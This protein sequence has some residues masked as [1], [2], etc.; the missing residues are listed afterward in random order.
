[1]HLCPTEAYC[2]DGAGSGPT[3]LYLN[4]PAFAGEQW[5]PVVHYANH[6]DSVR[7]SHRRANDWVLVGTIDDLSW[8]TCMTYDQIH[9]ERPEP[10]WGLDGS[11]PEL[12]E[13]ILC[14]QNPN[15]LLK[16]QTFAQQLDPIWLDESHGWTGG[17]HDDAMK[18]CE[19]L[20]KRKLCPYTA[21]ESIGTV[22]SRFASF[23][24]FEHTRTHLSLFL[25]NQIAH[26]DQAC[27]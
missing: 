2:P 5:A 11:Q 9:N 21:C 8:S 25:L 14:C 1:M 24:C 12:K 23:L 22:I 18:F 10:A 7:G 16:E 27:L 3:P 19:T 17:S 6:E 4:R 26:M 13:N 20:G 15:N